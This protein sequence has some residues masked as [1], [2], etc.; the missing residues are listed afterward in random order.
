MALGK[1]GRCWRKQTGMMGSSMQIAG[2]LGIWDCMQNSQASDLLERDDALFTVYFS[3]R[4]AMQT[5]L[6]P[7][8][9]GHTEISLLDDQI[10]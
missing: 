2:Q 3:R 5:V 9:F 10:M 1:S 8:H 4:C 7:R 6:R